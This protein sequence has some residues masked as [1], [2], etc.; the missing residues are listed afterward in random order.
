M[1]LTASNQY[2]PNHGNFQW[3]NMGQLISLENHN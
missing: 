2:T 1:K 3:K